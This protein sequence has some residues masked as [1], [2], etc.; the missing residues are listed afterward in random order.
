MHVRAALL[1][2]ASREQTMRKLLVVAVAGILAATSSA[3]WAQ[4][5]TVKK[6]PGHMMKNPKAKNTAPG[7]SEFAPGHLKRKGESASKYTPSHR[8][9]TGSGRR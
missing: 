4:S 3:G 9:T 1:R 5:D 7:A 2:G 6:T 8:S